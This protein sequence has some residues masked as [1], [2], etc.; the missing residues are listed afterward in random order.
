MAVYVKQKLVSSKVDE[1][2]IKDDILLSGIVDRLAMPEVLHDCLRVSIDGVVIPKENWMTTTATPK[3]VVFVAVVPGTDGDGKNPLAMI[4]MVALSVFSM[5]VVAP[6]FAS[7]IVGNIAAVGVMFVGMLAINALFPPPT[8]STPSTLEDSSG[9]FGMEGLRNRARPHKAVRNIFGTYKVSPDI[10]VEPY[11]LTS[12]DIQTL[13][14]I[15]DFG[16]GEIDISE[17][18]I[19]NTPIANYTNTYAIHKN[20]TDGAL[21]YYQSDNVSESFSTEIQGTRITRATDDEANE[22]H[23][24]IKFPLGLALYLEEGGMTVAEAK[25]ELYVEKTDGSTGFISGADLPYINTSHS[26]QYETLAPLYLI[27]TN[28]Y[29]DY[30]NATYPFLSY[31]VM[32]ASDTFNAEVHGASVSSATSAVNPP[33]VLVGQTFYLNGVTYTLITVPT[34]VITTE[35]IITKT[36]D[37][38]GDEELVYTYYKVATYT[39]IVLDS[40]TVSSGVHIPYVKIREEGASYWEYTFVPAV[41]D[42]SVLLSRPQ[43]ANFILVRSTSQPFVFSI[44]VRFPSQGEWNIHIRR[45]PAYAWIPTAPVLYEASEGW[46]D[47]YA[48]RTDLIAIQSVTTTRAPLAFKVPH[49]ILELKIQATDKISGVVDTLTATCQ[50]VLHYYVDGIKQATPKATSNPAW[51]ALQILMGDENP[52]PIPLTRI[53]ISAYEAWAAFCGDVGD[54]TDD[55]HADLNWD[56]NSTVFE[57]LMSTFSAGRATLATRENKY[58]VVYEQFPTVPTQLLTTK[59]SYGFKGTKI[60]TKQPHALNVGFIDKLSEWQMVDR[61]VYADGYAEIADGVGDLN[62][63]DANGDPVDCLEA[64]YFERISLPFCTSSDRAWKAGRYYIAQGKLRPESFVVS[65][66]IENLLAERGDLIELQYDAARMGGSPSRITAITGAVVTLREPVSWA[67]TPNYFLRIRKDDGSQEEIQVI[68]QTDSYTI[69]LTSVPSP[70]AKIGDLVVYGEEDFVTDQFLVKSVTPNADLTATFNLVPIA[71]AIA[72]ADTGTIPNYEPPISSETMLYPVCATGV[73]IMVNLYYEDRYPK[74]DVSVNWADVGTNIIYE[75]WLS[76]DGTDNY[77]LIAL[78]EYEVDYALIKGLSTLDRDYNSTDDQLLK[79]LP[80]NAF[81]YKPQIDSCTAYAFRLPVDETPPGKPLFFAG[82]I[83][84]DMMNL[85]WLPP[86]DED[87]G[88]YML[89]YTSDV[90][91]AD[92]DNA[93]TQGSIIP[94]NVTSTSIAARV[95]SYMLKAIDTSGNL[96]TEYAIVRTTIPA[97]LGFEIIETITEHSAFL[98]IKTN[99]EVVGDTLR[100]DLDVDQYEQY[101]TYVFSDVVNLDAVYNSYVTVDLERTVIALDGEDIRENDTDVLVQVRVSSQNPS[102]A[103]WTTLS[104]VAAMSNSDEPISTWLDL[105]DTYVETMSGGEESNWSGWQ[106]FYAGY[107]TAKYLEFRAVLISNRTYLTPSITKLAVTVS[108]PARIESDNDVT[109]AVNGTSIAFNASFSSTPSIGITQDAMVKNDYFN[110]TN[111]SVSGFDIEFFDSSSSSVARQFDWLAKGFGE[112]VT[113]PINAIDEGDEDDISIL[114]ATIA[115][116]TNN[117]IR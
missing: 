29:T 37:I 28:L 59:N 90:T 47:K 91:T 42:V 49:T 108:S 77:K 7:A 17:I 79:I 87:I 66:D 45:L 67:A 110:I 6:Y 36:V 106:T 14:A 81:G 86:V 32:R 92:W 21:T 72:D 88:G 48:D 55:Y 65:T 63:F 41:G 96:S 16:Y 35:T 23:I 109:C 13:Y 40:A 111:Q 84:N 101:G 69:T 12:G 103:D 76:S 68:S 94:Y 57:R 74:V 82:N 75:M 116:I 93:P 3:N 102:I 60:F 70:T 89:K 105:T 26:V 31:S 38:D 11:V 4:A 24:D 30:Y 50:R 46:P 95:G 71:R 54:D 10:A 1:H 83:S 20:Y 78:V 104:S 9:F 43:S 39:G 53:D 85:T 61:I 52:D 51:I 117:L 2:I 112:S 56:A 80:V 5:Y 73:D 19:G 62:C 115:A 34:P 25:F 107:F 99:T 113:S 44:N 22:A 33:L 64:T 8:L 15:Y 97:L 58:S 27:I 114:P 98:G 100:L 18:L